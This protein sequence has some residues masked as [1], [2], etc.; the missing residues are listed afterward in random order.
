[1]VVDGVHYK[2]VWKK[3]IVGSSFFIPCIHTKIAK[4]EVKE[5]MRILGMKVV[6]KLV[7]ENEIRGLRIWRV[8]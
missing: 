2:V 8:R 5:T 3:F 6:M 4:K 1:M 7:I